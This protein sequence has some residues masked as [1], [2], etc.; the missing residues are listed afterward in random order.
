MMLRKCK[1]ICV[2]LIVA[3]L[4]VT[5]LLFPTQKA[6]ALNENLV[7]GEYNGWLEREVDYEYKTDKYPFDGILKLIIDED[8]GCCYVFF[9][10]YDKRIF[11]GYDENIAISF[12]VSNIANEYKFSINKNGFIS[13]DEEDMSAVDIAYNFDNIHSQGGGGQAFVGFELKHQFDREQFNYIKCEYSAGVDRVTTLFDNQLLDMYVEPTTPTTKQTTAKKTAK[14]KTI[15]QTT[16]KSKSSNS[17]EKTTKFKGSGTVKYTDTAKYNSSDDTSQKFFAESYDTISDPS[18]E[19]KNTDSY[20]SSN[21]AANTPTTLSKSAIILI[22]IASILVISGIIL[23]VIASVT[24]TK[25]EKI[26]EDEINDI[27]KEDE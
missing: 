16:V 2:F 15:K 5:P 25:E 12:T 17:D 26:Q 27:P 4:L 18:D 23:I 6:Y 21:T 1:D 24:K 7:A 10:F 22:I 13:T 19:E 20:E 14:E 3:S 8:S 9:S 11:N